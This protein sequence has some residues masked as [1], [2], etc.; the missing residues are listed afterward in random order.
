V[1]VEQDDADVRAKAF[2][3]QHVAPQNF[4]RLGDPQHVF[5]THAFLRP[6]HRAIWRE[7]RDANI[8][9]AKNGCICQ[10]IL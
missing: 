3:V 1:G 5:D 2:T 7:N 4:L 9:C 8:K 6:C 10:L